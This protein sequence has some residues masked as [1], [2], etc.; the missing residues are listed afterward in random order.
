MLTYWEVQM[1]TCLNFEVLGIPWQAIN[2]LQLFRMRI[3]LLRD[4]KTHQDQSL[5][6]DTIVL[7]DELSRM[8]QMGY[9]TRHKEGRYY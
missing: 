1:Q 7:L 2:R 3:R 8:R 9:E 4:F 5:V 6:S